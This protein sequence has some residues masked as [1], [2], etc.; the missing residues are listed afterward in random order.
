MG[1][2]VLLLLA[3]VVVAAEGGAVG[4]E[5]PSASAAQDRVQSQSLKCEFC[6][7]SVDFVCRTYFNPE[8]NTTMTVSG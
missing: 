4:P 6:K 1:R 3:L 7:Y 5:V 8:S 2:G